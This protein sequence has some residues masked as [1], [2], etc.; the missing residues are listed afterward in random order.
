MKPLHSLNPRNIRLALPV[1]TLLIC[2]A[3]IAAPALTS[4][5]RASAGHSGNATGAVKGSSKHSPTPRAFSTP[6]KGDRSQDSDKEAAE[7]GGTSE[8]FE[9]PLSN[10]K[11]H[12]P[13]AR[14][15]RLTPSSALTVDAGQEVEPNNSS[16]TATPL[17][18][19]DVKIKGNIFPNADVDFYSFTAA[20]GDRVYAATMTS[21]SASASVDS[22]L[23]L[24]ASDGSTVVEGDNDDGSFGST[25]SSIAG[26][27]ITT[28]GT[29]YLRVRHNLA[30]SQLRPY[31]LYLKVQSGSPT[32]ETESN[33]TFP[34]Q[35]LPVSGWVSGSTSSTA[36]VDFYAITL[37]AGDTVY[38]SL[39][40]DPERDTTEWNGQLGLGP[41]GT[42]A[43]IL[44]V[45]D[46]G[47]ATPD[48]EAFFMTVQ[49]AGTYGIFVGVPTGGSTFGT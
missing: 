13:S 14:Q 18:G 3:L 9:I 44:V 6:Q 37:A 19:T 23:D 20:A 24:I 45:S 4:V 36:D 28:P 10:F 5:E 41:F 40:L 15:P 11:T 17:G 31:D 22:F 1:I 12:D 33:D 29:Y 30:T 26:R 32:P 43:S 35:P 39:D 47:A 42:P 25:S 48:S 49:D 2:C 38:L 46:A 34:G 8:L 7:A 16:A 27:Q 21:F